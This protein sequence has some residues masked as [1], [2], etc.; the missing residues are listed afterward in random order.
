LYLDKD[1]FYYLDLGAGR[2]QLVQ[3]ENGVKTVIATDKRLAIISVQTVTYTVS[4]RKHSQNTEIDVWRI[5]SADA[6]G[7]NIIS[8]VVPVS[9][10][11]IGFYH[12]YSLKHY[13]FL[14][15]DIRVDVF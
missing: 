8:A 13:R 5:E 14:Y 1:N 12:A 9:M 7:E 2:G 11:T 3:V 15:D 6:E 4:V 10:G